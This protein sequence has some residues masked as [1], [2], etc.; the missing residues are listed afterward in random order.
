MLLIVA[1]A[2]LALQD[3]GKTSPSGALSAAAVAPSA[4][5]SAAAARKWLALID[6]QQWQQSWSAAGSLFTSHISAADWQARAQ[7][8]RQQLGPVTSRTLKTVTKANALPG[9][10]DGQYEILQFATDFAQKGPGIETVT[11]AHEPSGWKVD[12]YFI[13]PAPPPA[14]TAPAAPAK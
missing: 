3:A 11:L 7:P 13:A 5:E 1:V 4:S 14:A 10:P 2:V 8:L 12:G 6:S 9:A